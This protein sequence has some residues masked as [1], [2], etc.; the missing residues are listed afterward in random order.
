MAKRGLFEEYS[1][2]GCEGDEECEIIS[3]IHKVVFVP[4]AWV[5]VVWC[6]RGLFGVVICRDE[7]GGGRQKCTIIFGGVIQI[8]ATIKIGVCTCPDP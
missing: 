3:T 7:S 5:T 1:Y 6:K 2:N 8:N 4:I